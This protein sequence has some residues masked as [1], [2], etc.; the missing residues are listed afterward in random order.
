VMAGLPANCYTLL[1]FTLLYLPGT[2]TSCLIFSFL[3][4][5]RMQE[6]NKSSSNVWKV[7]LACPLK[8]DQQ[9]MKLLPIRLSTA[10][11][12]TIT[13]SILDPVLWIVQL[14]TF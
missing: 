10:R 5:N 6:V 9:S 13:L 12:W 2:A 3:D 1:Y 11:C 14:F 8:H 4:G 7:E